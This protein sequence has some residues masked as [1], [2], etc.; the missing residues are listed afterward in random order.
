MLCPPA[1]IDARPQ[2]Y[3]APSPSAT[4]IGGAR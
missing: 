3:L 4:T 1:P 2:A